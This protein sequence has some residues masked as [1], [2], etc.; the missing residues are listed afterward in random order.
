MRAK[1]LV[2]VP[3]FALILGACTAGG[4]VRPEPVGSSPASDVLLVDTDR[5]PIAISPGTGT[6]LS[7]GEGGVAGPDGSRLYS[8]TSARP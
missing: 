6:V 1:V 3:A 2:V 4:G 8:A 7:D 5:G